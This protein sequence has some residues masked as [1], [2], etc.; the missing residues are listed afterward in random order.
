MLFFPFRTISSQ[1]GVFTNPLNEYL[2]AVCDPGGGKTNTFNRV[3]QPVI[4]ILNKKH[5]IQ[6]QLQNYTGAGLQ[7]HQIDNKGYGLITGD[8][9]ERF[10]SSITMKQS[11]GEA[12]KALL[13]QLWGGRGD[14]NQL[15]NGSRGFEK[16][17]ISACLFIQPECFLKEIN[18]LR[19][20]D[21]LMDRF[22]VISAKPVF[23]KSASIRENLGK[24]Q[25]SPMGD[26]VNVMERI[27]RE[28]QHGVSYVLSTG[29]LEAYDSIVD[30]FAD[31]VQER[32]GS[33]DGNSKN[34]FTAV[35]ST[36]F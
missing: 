22:L 29:A 18:Q 30:G 14:T 23:Y 9:G 34:V 27:Y 24:L 35:T 3:V 16:T 26:F 15:V 32:Y 31:Y 2:I 19:G 33:D 36:T 11:K 1:E 25:D 20:N 10:F 17:S 21:G 28:H 5:G 12:E 6:I 4:D 13:C 7:K 8:E